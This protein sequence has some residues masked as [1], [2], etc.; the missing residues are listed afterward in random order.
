MGRNRR[1]PTALLE[2]APAVDWRQVT[3]AMVA[4]GSSLDAIADALFVPKPTLQSWRAGHQPNHADGQAVLTLHERMLNAAARVNEPFR[5]P[6][7]TNW[8]TVISDMQNAGFSL[9]D[10]GGAIGVARS[11]VRTWQQGAA[12]GFE[13][14]RALLMLSET[15]RPYVEAARQAA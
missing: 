6:P 13:A 1:T 11:T 2:R 9:R 15:V 7:P 10:I 14:G 3:D 5:R 12:P 4:A 8:G